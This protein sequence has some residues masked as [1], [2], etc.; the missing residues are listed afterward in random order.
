MFISIISVLVSNA[1][2]CM[3]EAGMGLH[4]CEYPVDARLDLR[5][6]A[7]Q[8]VLV[9]DATGAEVPVTLEE[10]CSDSN[11]NVGGSCRYALAPEHEWAAGAAYTVWA[12]F[13]AYAEVHEDTFELTIA[14]DGRRVDPVAGVPGLTVRRLAYEA[15][16][17][18]CEPSDPVKY[19][20]TVT[21]AAPGDAD[22]L[23]YL[24]ITRT[25]GYLRTL[26]VPEDGAPFDTEFLASGAADDCFTIVQIDGAGNESESLDTCVDESDA[27]VEAE[28]CGCGGGR[29][30]SGWVVLL[31][32]L[33]GVRRR[34]GGRG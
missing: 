33:A 27:P 9:F 4:T 28:A 29:L 30:A 24:Q 17:N 26:P 6:N 5:G 3:A 14:A 7:L 13:W 15:E 22:G 11:S 19:A 8:D 20:L 16:W 1:T 34:G 32:G 31:G 10:T 18:S 21:P 12:S 23:S 2:A 25:D